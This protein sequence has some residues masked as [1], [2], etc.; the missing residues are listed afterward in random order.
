VSHDLEDS[1]RTCRTERRFRPPSRKK[2]DRD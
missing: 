1:T 2:Q